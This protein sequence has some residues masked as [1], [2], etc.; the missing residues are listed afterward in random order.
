MGIKHLNRLLLSQCSDRSI[1]N[2][3]LSDL[4][5]KTVV[6]DTSIYLYKFLEKNALLENIYLMINVLQKYNILPVF[7]FDGKPPEE[8]REL[9]MKRRQN[10][11]NAENK[12]NAIVASLASTATTLSNESVVVVSNELER[13]K[14]RFIRITPDHISLAQNLMDAFGVPYLFSHGESDQLCAFLVKHQFAY[15]CVSD[16]MDM[17]L[18]GCPRV[19]RFVNF[20]QHECTMYDFPVILEEMRMTATNFRDAIIMSGTDYNMHDYLFPLHIT[21]EMYYGE[22]FQRAQSQSGGNL[23]FYEFM[24]MAKATNNTIGMNQKEKMDRTRKL[25]DMNEYMV[26]GKQ[27]IKEVIDRLPFQQE[28]IDWTKIKEIMRMDGFL[29]A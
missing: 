21:M 18:Y 14:R 20:I 1:R 5:K 24:M 26:H 22:E 7:I 27:E 13:L 8:K 23:S 11:D 6:I 16:D 10:K 25:F 2:V 12:Y 19:L 17:F 9:L 3:H 29:F 4:A 28:N 15:A